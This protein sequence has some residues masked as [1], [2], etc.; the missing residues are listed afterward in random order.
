[1]QS[2]SGLVLS[3]LD[4][5]IRDELEHNLG[6]VMA[7]TQATTSRKVNRWNASKKRI[8]TDAPICFARLRKTPSTQSANGDQELDQAEGKLPVQTILSIRQ[9][10][11]LMIP[12]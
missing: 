2:F 8:S 9:H 10:R 12:R 1:M 4:R 6:G 3:D 7:V 5:D 11:D